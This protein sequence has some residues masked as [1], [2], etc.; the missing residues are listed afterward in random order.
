MSTATNHAKR[1][2][3]SNYRARMFNGSRKSVIK[4]TVKKSGFMAFIRMIRDAFKR[5]KETKSDV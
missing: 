5:N 4:P 2:H 3:R 1:S